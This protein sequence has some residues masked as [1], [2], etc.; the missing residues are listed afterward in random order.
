MQARIVLLQL[1]LMKVWIEGMRE[2]GKEGKEGR[3][4][5]V[6]FQAKILFFISQP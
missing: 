4:S 1:W 2:E 5:L 3:R 6:Q